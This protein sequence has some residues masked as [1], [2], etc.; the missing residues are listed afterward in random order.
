MNPHDLKR[1]DIVVIKRKL[2]HV[3]TTY[4]T[5]QQCDCRPRDRQPAIKVQAVHAGTHPHRIIL[6]EDIE[7]VEPQLGAE[8]GGS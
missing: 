5:L 3:G 2:E 1:G 7:S 6:L 4:R 8:I